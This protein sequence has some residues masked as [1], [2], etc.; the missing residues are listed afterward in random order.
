M[1]L[2]P[3]GHAHWDIKSFRVEGFY[4]DGVWATKGVCIF[5]DCARSH[6]PSQHQSPKSPLF[7]DTYY[8]LG[9][10]ND[11]L[12][13]SAHPSLTTAQGEDHC[14]SEFIAEEM[15]FQRSLITC[16][17]SHSWGAVRWELEFRKS[18]SSHN[19][20]L[21]PKTHKYQGKCITIVGPEE[22]CTDN[23]VLY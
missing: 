15:K 9:T 5:T 17:R 20:P 13:T 4:G 12:Y 2:S 11:S 16:P 23:I 6:T 10:L 8:V 3:L 21:L 19:S 22:R 7:L 14:Y 1:L 18:S